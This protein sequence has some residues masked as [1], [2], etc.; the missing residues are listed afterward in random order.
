MATRGYVSEQDLHQKGYGLQPL[1]PHGTTPMEGV[2][3][4]PHMCP[5]DLR[6]PIDG[7]QSKTTN[8]QHMRHKLRWSETTVADSRGPEKPFDAG[9]VLLPR[10][11][12]APMSSCPEPGASHLNVPTQMP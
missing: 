9:E 12:V 10:C 4:E 1:T 2:R 8:R 11:P 5:P 3:R 7:C 6:D